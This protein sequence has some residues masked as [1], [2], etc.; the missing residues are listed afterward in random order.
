MKKCYFLFFLIIS[1]LIFALPGEWFRDFVRDYRSAYD[2]PTDDELL[3]KI[4]NAI[5]DASKETGLDPLLI[6]S[7]IIVESEFR[8]VIGMYGELGMMQIKPET[9]DF[10]ANYYNL[11]KPKE[12]W[13]RILWDFKLN[14]KIGS[15]YLKYLY[16][17]FG[18]IQ[19]AVKH[20]NGGIYKEVYA[21]KILKKYNQM[22][23]VASTYEK[24]S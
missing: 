2:L 16:D 13:T 15:Y 12:G 3:L 11:E 8:N 24:N 7:V 14:I 23:K 17:K 19:K 18:S 4:E 9:A 1:S 21:E 6:T 10:V 22:L 20:Y 5:L